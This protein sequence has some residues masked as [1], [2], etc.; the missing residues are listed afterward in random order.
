MD[1]LSEYINLLRADKS[2]ITQELCDRVTPRGAFYM[3][4]QLIPGQFR[5]KEL[6]MRCLKR[7]PWEYKF[8]PKEVMDKEMWAF[9][10]KQKGRI[11]NEDNVPPEIIDQEMY[12]I[13]VVYGGLKLKDVPF[14]FRNITI[15]LHALRNE[16]YWKIRQYIPEY[17]KTNKSY[18]RDLASVR[19]RFLKSIPVEDRTFDICKAAIENDP[20]AVRYLPN[21]EELMPI[22][23]ALIEN[24]EGDDIYW[25][26]KCIPT[27]YKTR[28]VCKVAV[29]KNS[30]L[31]RKIPREMVD[32]EMCDI[33]WPNDG[34]DN[35]DSSDSNDSDNREINAKL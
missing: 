24:Y 23:I 13:A 33:A 27:Y 31:L 30:G 35:E 1:A 2:R 34:S 17:I 20:Y 10:F 8:V 7:S 29:A 12:E 25:I 9:V 18:Y 16:W 5:T 32:T 15:C 14:D 3:P 11:I 21:S 22:I 19:G 4:L 6:C 26:F 28:D